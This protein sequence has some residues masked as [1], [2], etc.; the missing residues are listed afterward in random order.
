M[1]FRKM[2]ICF[3]FRKALVCVSGIALMG[4]L[5]AGKIEDDRSLFTV[6]SIGVRLVEGL[7]ID[8]M[9]RSVGACFGLLARAPRRTK[10]ARATRPRPVR[11]SAT[12]K[13]NGAGKPLKTT[14]RKKKN[15]A[16]WNKYAQEVAEE[17]EALSQ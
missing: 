9:A 15:T 4:Q 13:G 6:S 3:N 14:Q 12:Q 17:T 10:T 16:R 11:C 2:A 8:S 1:N 7:R 5:A